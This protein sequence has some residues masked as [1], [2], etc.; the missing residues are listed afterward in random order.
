M[1][2]D[3]ALVLVGKWLEGD[4][5]SSRCEAQHMSQHPSL[6]GTDIDSIRVLAQ[7]ASHDRDG[8][9]VVEAVLIVCQGEVGP[10]DGRLEASPDDQVFCETRYRQ[11]HSKPLDT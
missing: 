5:L 9:P 11:G 10:L 8:L 3:E 6:E 2:L 7:D 1:F 4:V